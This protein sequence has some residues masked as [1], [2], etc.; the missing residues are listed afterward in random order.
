[1]LLG[2]DCVS[3]PEEERLRGREPVACSQGSRDLEW[4]SHGESNGRR[5][6]E[7]CQ[8]YEPKR[9]QTR[10][11]RVLHDEQRRG[12]VLLMK[13][14][15]QLLAQLPCCSRYERSIREC[16][17]VVPGRTDAPQENVVRLNHRR[18]FPEAKLV[19]VSGR[20]DV[21]GQVAA[22]EAQHARE[23]RRSAPV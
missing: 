20:Q 15:R 2:F 1:M 19:V 17:H 7:L 12:T 16:R 14:E 8:N 22:N 5:N 10:D 6:L 18:G 21:L 9:E 23:R 11:S 3:Q 13:Q 4:V